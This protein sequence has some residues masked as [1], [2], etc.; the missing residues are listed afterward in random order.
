MRN[1]SSLISEPG[2][3]LTWQ[4]GCPVRQHNVSKGGWAVTDSA[5]Q[6]LP[7]GVI[8]H[9]FVDMRVVAKTP[10]GALAAQEKNRLIVLTTHNLQ[11]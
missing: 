10:H 5:N 4:N 9:Q 3:R 2:H 7:G 11:R 8:P 1:N 6:L